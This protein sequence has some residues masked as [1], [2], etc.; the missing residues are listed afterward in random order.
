MTVSFKQPR[1]KLNV[2][3]LQYPKLFEEEKDTADA[4]EESTF[5]QD[6]ENHEDRYTENP[7]EQDTI[8]TDAEETREQELHFQE[9][10][11]ELA[12][13]DKSA[14]VQEEQQVQ[15]EEK[16]D[17][18]FVEPKKEAKL[19]DSLD[20]ENP[21][22]DEQDPVKRHTAK[23]KE[24]EK[25]LESTKQE[26]KREDEENGVF[27]YR[28]FKLADKVNALNEERDELKDDLDLWQD[29]DL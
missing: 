25:E 8:P 26:L 24:V 5:E 15:T 7:Y 17:E 3:P 22:E 11:T 9:K 20:I 10:A 23:L 1:E 12:E 16:K 18:A 27:N 2:K 29:N 21:F 14:F 28:S 19:W 4:P 13:Q 6:F